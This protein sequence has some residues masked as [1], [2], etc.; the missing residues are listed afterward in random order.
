MVYFSS[1]CASHV[2]YIFLRMLGFVVQLVISPIADPG[3]MSSFQAWPHSLE[4]IDP[5]ILLRYFS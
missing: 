5:E 1:L 2:V 4:E 3:V